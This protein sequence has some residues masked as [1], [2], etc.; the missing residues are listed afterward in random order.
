MIGETAFRN[1]LRDAA[2]PLL[3]PGEKIDRVIWAQAGDPRQF[4]LISVVC[5]VFLWEI[6]RFWLLGM[7][8]A[9][10][11]FTMTAPRAIVVTN[12]ALLILVLSYRWFSWKGK[13]LERLPRETLLGPIAPLPGLGRLWGRTT[14]NGKL[15]FVP[16]RYHYDIAAADGERSPVHEDQPMKRAWCSNCKATF[17]EAQRVWDSIAESGT[18]PECCRVGSIVEDTGTSEHDQ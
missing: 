1:Q 18:C 13:L 8:M 2:K 15:L 14:L 10:I 12:R 11:F 17:D 6:A 5:G 16:R 9:S 7:A 4:L 3:E